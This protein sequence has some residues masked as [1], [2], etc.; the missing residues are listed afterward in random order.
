MHKV[1]V[2]SKRVYNESTPT[3]NTCSTNDP[4]DSGIRKVNKITA[5]GNLIKTTQLTESEVIAESK[6]S[7]VT[8]SK[9]EE[10]L[11]NRT[12]IINHIKRLS[13]EARQEVMDVLENKQVFKDHSIDAYFEG[14]DDADQN[15][16]NELA[17]TVS[18]YWDAFCN[19]FGNIFCR[20]ISSS[21]LY[22]KIIEV[23]TDAS[24][25]AK[26]TY[27]HKNELSGILSFGEVDAQPEYAK[28]INGVFSQQLSNAGEYSNEY[29][30]NKMTTQEVKSELESNIASFKSEI[31]KNTLSI[32]GYNKFINCLDI[33]RTNLKSRNSDEIID[34]G[35]K[36]I[37]RSKTTGDKYLAYT[38][39]DFHKIQLNLNAVSKEHQIVDDHFTSI[40]KMFAFLYAIQI[41]PSFDKVNGLIDALLSYNGLSK[42]FKNKLEVRKNNLTN[43]NIKYLS[44]LVFDLAEDL[45]GSYKNRVNAKINELDRKNDILNKK[46]NQTEI[47]I[48]FIDKKD[49]DLVLL[50]NDSKRVG[51]LNKSIEALNWLSETAT[52]LLSLV[53]ECNNF[54]VENADKENSVDFK[55]AYYLAVAKRKN[56]IR[57]KARELF[58]ESSETY[59][60]ISEILDDNQNFD[61]LVIK[62][63]LKVEP[64]SISRLALVETYLEK[65]MLDAHVESCAHKIELEK[66]EERRRKILRG[67]ALDA[68]S[69]SEEQIQISNNQS[70][71]FISDDKSHVSDVLIDSNISSMDIFKDGNYEIF[72]SWD[73]LNL[74]VYARHLSTGDM[75]EIRDEDSFV[76]QYPQSSDSTVSSSTAS[77]KNQRH[78]AL[79]L[80][81]SSLLNDRNAGVNNNGAM[82]YPNNTT[83]FKPLFDEDD[84]YYV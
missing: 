42:S 36:E 46:V 67:E 7:V 1:T 14:I 43:E 22:D 64:G 63:G 41:N 40:S 70:N 2:E 6:S 27:Q 39:S 15:E 71:S 9:K 17:V 68:S 45:I 52:K 82:K 51:E 12:K 78:N 13:P 8:E 19:I 76:K 56:D 53:D 34:K 61:D 57:D 44:D 35:T 3:V 30:S 83:E 55:N 50:K 23:K 49:R 31:E 59:S 75:I 10:L 81:A 84:V 77:S 69:V 80:Q 18:T 38:A 74:I 26:D 11:K 33:A 72:N 48:N 62:F 16:V 79:N 66:I 47:K 5:L 54:I 73:G 32:D 25:Q 21:A 37:V 28:I 60:D 58:S 20:R 29:I 24:L 65:L 4:V